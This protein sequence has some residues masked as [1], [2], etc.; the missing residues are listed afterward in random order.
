MWVLD[1]QETFLR[2]VVWRLNRQGGYGG[3]SV[4]ASEA[5]EFGGEF[6]WWSGRTDTANPLML[7]HLELM[8]SIWQAE[9]RP[10]KCG[11][12]QFVRS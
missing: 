8:M 12:C 2:D 4:M 7:A 6:S 5:G 9:F 3:S 1:R 10:I 11:V